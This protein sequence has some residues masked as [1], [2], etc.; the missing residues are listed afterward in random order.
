ML[1]FYGYKKPIKINNQ[2]CLKILTLQIKQTCNVEEDKDGFKKLIRV[3]RLCVAKRG[4]VTFSYKRENYFFARVSLLC[5][6]KAK[7]NQE[8]EKNRSSVKV[9]SFICSGVT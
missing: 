3:Y 9:K 7:S 6:V 8:T 5:Q 1:T 2:F 4:V